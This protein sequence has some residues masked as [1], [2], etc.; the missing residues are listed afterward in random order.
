MRH[1]LY[2]KVPFKRA[3]KNGYPIYVKVEDKTTIYVSDIN[4]KK[5]EQQYVL[6]Y[7]EY[8]YYYDINGRN[9]DNGSYLYGKIPLIYSNLFYWISGFIFTLAVS[10]IFNVKLIEDS[11]PVIIFCG[12]VS[13]W[14]LLLKYWREN[15]LKKW[16]DKQIQ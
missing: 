9:R 2:I 15:E 6:T 16:I 4:L 1:L 12:I 7:G 5:V 13:I 8:K 3:K 11:T 10:I 14:L